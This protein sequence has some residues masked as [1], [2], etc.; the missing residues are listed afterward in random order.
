MKIKVNTLWLL[1]LFIASTFIIT[2]QK[3]DTPDNNNNTVI[4]Y[5]QAYPNASGELVQVLLGE[6]TVTCELVNGE[7]VFQGDI[8]LQPSTKGSVLS[9]R[10]RWPNNTVYYEIS[11]KLYEKSKLPDQTRITEAIKELKYYTNIKFIKRTD[12]SNYVEFVYDKI[13]CSSYVGMK[14]G[15]QKIR[16]ADWGWGKGTVI[17]E[18]CHALGLLHEHSKPGRDTYITI[19][20][21]NIIDDKMHNFEEIETAMPNTSG[22][23]FESI[24]LYGSY[25]T[26]DFA[27]DSTSPIIVKKDGSAFN[28]QRERL[29]PDDIKIINVIYPDKPTVVT[30]SINNITKNS[31]ISGGN[32]TKD[33]GYHILQKGV[34]WN[35]TQDPTVLNSKTTNGTGV[36]TYSSNLSGLSPNTTYY[37]RAYATNA[38]GTAYGGQLSFRTEG[39]TNEPSEPTVTTNNVSSITQTTATCGGN[40]TSSG[41]STVTAR[42]VCWDTS[43]NPTRSDSKTTDGSG[44]GS[45]TSKLTGLQSNCQYYVRAYATNSEGTSYG[46]QISFYT[47]ASSNSI[48]PSNGC[49][50]APIM[51]PYITYNVSIDVG[52]YDLAA[53]IDNHSYGSA[54]V[55]GFWLAFRTISDWGADHDVKIFNVSN[56]F[57]PVFGIRNA[58]NSPYLAHSPNML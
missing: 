28:A 55:R 14:G 56:N 41:S 25:T 20:E 43:K 44:T 53:P 49:S 31:A 16:L 6:E 13:G 34:C 2:C 7:Y 42:G 51:E 39:N 1:W 29:S 17:H 27:K 22:F 3:H 46:D 45:F 52:N 54:N 15:R 33:G 21:D 38:E 4:S 23:D 32:I 50:S 57:D 48:T 10:S 36:G 11:S 19:L 12:E 26:S 37:V 35:I 30:L 9:T 58:C 24:M 18:I 47:K 8:I 40:V 5:E